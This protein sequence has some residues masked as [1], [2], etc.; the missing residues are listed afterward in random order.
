MEALT[1][2]R[3]PQFQWPPTLYTEQLFE[4]SF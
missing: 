2:V 1:L 3:S 4:Q